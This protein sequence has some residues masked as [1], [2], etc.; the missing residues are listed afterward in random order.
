MNF[1]GR[2]YPNPPDTLPRTWSY[3]GYNDLLIIKKKLYWH[4]LPFY[5]TCRWNPLF[6][7]ACAETENDGTTLG[8][9]SNSTLAPLREDNINATWVFN[10]KLHVHCFGYNHTR[11][12]ESDG[13][14]EVEEGT[15]P[16]YVTRIR[17]SIFN[18]FFILQ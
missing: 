8:N 6:L 1:Q 7:P 17:L 2:G 14:K 15:I 12:V 10:S 13:K 4:C 16:S 11:T 5:I 18:F 3:H 9:L